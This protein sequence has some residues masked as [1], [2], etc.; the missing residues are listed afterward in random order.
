MTARAAKI[1]VV[2]FWMAMVGWFFQR[3]PAVV[4]EA[5]E[6]LP[7]LSKIAQKEGD[8][9]YGTYFIDK[10][11]GDK[12]K[13]GYS[14]TS[15]VKTERGYIISG[16]SRLK[17]DTQGTRAE[18]RIISKL[19]T[20]LDN[21]LLSI[22]F[23][24]LSDSVKFEMFGKV[25]GDMLDMDIRTA[26]GSQ[27]KTLKLPPDTVMPET[28]FVEA[29]REGLEVGETIKAPYLDAASFSIRETEMT[30]AETKQLE[31][32]S[33]IYRMTGLAMGMPIEAWIDENGQTLNSSAGMIF[34][35]LE[36]EEQALTTGWADTDKVPTDLVE[37]VSVKPD[38]II[39]SPR[40]AKMLKLRLT[41]VDLAQFAVG[42]HR[43]TLDGDV[44]TIRKEDPKTSVPL[45]SI[46]R[47]KFVKELESTPTIQ[48]NDRAIRS[49]A[50]E[51]LDEETDALKAAREIHDWVYESIEKKP[52]VSI[53]SARDVLDIKRG[54]CNEHSILFTAL[55]R[56]VGL[57][58]RIEV[59]LVY[60]KKGFYYHA[61]N[62]VYVGE[63]VTIDPTF[64]Q[65]PADAAHLKLLSGD[66][67]AQVPILATIGQLG[68][69]VLE[70]K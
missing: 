41:G 52:L 22:D 48:V 65:F 60:F 37:Q 29:I 49:K 50:F 18:V 42:D 17:I 58:T 2:V 7:S 57:P 63:W 45:K 70:V 67:D 62:A 28:M 47:S 21:R 20:D 35:K 30:L 10:K 39:D 61:W 51:I 4:S 3:R 56:A 66:L 24:M 43:Q 26:G 54:D 46:D 14:K 1:F 59:G 34:T 15:T 16:E 64:G 32:G 33:T 5:A 11:T 25:K 9:W 38:K 53:P 23:H 69:Q 8:L 12:F 13:I 31:D 40:A 68:I 36:T 19:L 44:V 6:D 55:A 27:H